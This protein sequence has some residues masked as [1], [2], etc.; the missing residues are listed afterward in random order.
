MKLEGNE[1]NLAFTSISRVRFELQR[2]SGC[3]R[4]PKPHM[5]Q[6]AAMLVSPR[7]SP[8]NKDEG[9]RWGQREKGNRDKEEKKGENKGGRW[10]RKQRFAYSGGKLPA[11]FGIRFSIGKFCLEQML[12][13]G[14]IFLHIHAKIK[15]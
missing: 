4:S 15:Q 11:I 1:V 9:W 2:S 3:A 7:Q 14:L 5:L 12:C 10:Q 13:V 8:K 6:P